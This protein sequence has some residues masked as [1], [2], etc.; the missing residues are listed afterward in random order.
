MLFLAH[1]SIEEGWE[2]F[3]I[4]NCKLT[5]MGFAFRHN[6]WGLFQYGDIVLPV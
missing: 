4:N 2:L 6:I 5:W 1:A 3:H